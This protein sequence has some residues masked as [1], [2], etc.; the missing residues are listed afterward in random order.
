VQLAV[1]F[2][3]VTMQ[4]KLGETF[5]TIIL[6]EQSVQLPLLKVTKM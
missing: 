4:A 1:V 5:L 6:V 2:G 3:V